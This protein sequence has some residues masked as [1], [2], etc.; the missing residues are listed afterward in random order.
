M[1]NDT[2][3]L[4]GIAIVGVAGYLLWRSNQP[5]KKFAGFVLPPKC[6]KGYISVWVECPEGNCKPHWSCQLQSDWDW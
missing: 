3:I 2:K 6:P 5:Q 1:S 4:L